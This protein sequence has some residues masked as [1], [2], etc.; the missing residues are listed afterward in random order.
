MFGP[1]RSHNTSLNYPD[2]EKH[3][4]PK[5]CPKS[6]KTITGYTASKQDD[7]FMKGKGVDVAVFRPKEPNPGSP[8]VLEEGHEERP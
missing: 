4:G 6:R 1:N 5:Q 3:P 8:P 2:Q 7:T